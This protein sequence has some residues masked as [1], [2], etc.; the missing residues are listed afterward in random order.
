MAN[1]IEKVSVDKLEQALY[2]DNIVTDTLDGTDNVTFQV[3]RMISLSDMVLFVRE[4]VEACVDFEGGDYLPEA[5]DFAIRLGVLTHYAN[6][7]MAT[8]M[9]KQYMLVYGT[10]AFE[11]VMEHVN[12]EQFRD[13]VQAINKKIQYMVNLMS[14]SAVAKINEVINKLLDDIPLPQNNRNHQL[15]GDYKGCWECHIN[16]DWLLIYTKDKQIKIITLKRT[17]THSDLFKK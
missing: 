11:Q 15:V 4:V 2:K 14:S 17:G 5:Y 12:G 9:E 8:S 13:I 16:P 10:R 3:K 7:E 6:F 1:D